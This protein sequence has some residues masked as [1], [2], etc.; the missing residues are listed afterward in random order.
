[1]HCRFRRAPFLPRAHENRSGLF[2]YQRRNAIDHRQLCHR[3]IV[4]APV[5]LGREFVAGKIEQTESLRLPDEHVHQNG[6]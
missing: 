5:S 3:A 4:N 6:R 2:A 1:M